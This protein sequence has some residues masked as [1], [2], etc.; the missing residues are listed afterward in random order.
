MKER[1]TLRLKRRVR[2]T[3]PLI[4]AFCFAHNSSAVVTYEFTGGVSPFDNASTNVFETL[5]DPDSG[6]DITLTTVDIIGWDG[7]KASEGIN[8]KTNVSGS[9][10]KAMGINSA[11]T[12]PGAT[13]D[14]QNFDPGEGWVVSFNVAV[15]LVEIDFAS[16][17][18]GTEMTLLSSAFPD[19]LLDEEP[20]QT[21]G[22]H[23]LG[24]VLLPAGTELTF[25]MTSATNAPD[26]TIRIDELIVRPDLP[27]RIQ[28]LGDAELVRPRILVREEA[29]SKQVANAMHALHKHGQIKK[30]GTPGVW[31]AT[32]SPQPPKPSQKPPMAGRRQDLYF[33]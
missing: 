20:G 32:Y 12:P 23:D 29:G 9:S 6:L 2:W 16:Q 14:F 11:T 25:L 19:L 21:D 24:N 22:T 8:H 10:G 18:A 33:E 26:T 1:T 27:A 28:H 3:T 30:S 5:N 13:S 31:L 7:S 17:Q 15:Q 4:F